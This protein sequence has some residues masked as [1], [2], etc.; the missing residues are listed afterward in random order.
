ML[1]SHRPAATDA[2][3]SSL[4]DRKPAAHLLEDPEAW[5]EDRLGQAVVS[6]KTFVPDL[7]G[8]LA[9]LLLGWLAAVAVRW[10]IQRFGKGLDA[11]LTALH[12][13]TGQEFA[14]TTWSVSN[15]VGNVAFWIILIY[16][17]STASEQVGL[18]TFANWLRG[19]LG[20]LPRVL[21]G[22]FTVFIGYLIS[23]GVRNMIAAIAESKGF[24]HGV[25]VGQLAAGLILAFALLLA[26]AQLGLDVSLFADLVILAAAALFLGV[27]LAFGVGAADAVRN[28]MA[29]H[30][31]RKTYRP[32]QR[33]RL[34]GVEGDILEL[35]A[36]AVVL[37]TSEGEAWIPARKFLEAASVLL[38]EEGASRA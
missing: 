3:P 14:R 23:S 38:E 32:G 35:T 22:A 29:S 25:P 11:L 12:R 28:I 10:L 4:P 36:V 24:Q 7:L 13:W 1:S 33:V 6:L 15:L 27:G 34:E 21:I 26:L 20:Y 5:F 17:V 18:I 8:A 30:Y 2:I 31:V 37:E 16:T 9:L 19:L